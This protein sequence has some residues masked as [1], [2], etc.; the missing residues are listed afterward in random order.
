M[1]HI[2]CSATKKNASNTTNLATHLTARAETGDSAAF[3]HR[4]ALHSARIL[5]RILEMFLKSFSLVLAEWEE[6]LNAENA[7]AEA[8]LRLL[9]MSHLPNRYLAV[10][11]RSFLKKPRGAFI[12]EATGQSRDRR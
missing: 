1:R 11:E 5:A 9:L 6:H 7:V 8:I 2:K 10:S 3:L 4:A 12:A